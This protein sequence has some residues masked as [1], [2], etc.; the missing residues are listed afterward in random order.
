MN[1]V[2]LMIFLVIL[3]IF[4][5]AMSEVKLPSLSSCYLLLPA[6]NFE[7]LISSRMSTVI[8]WCWSGARPKPEDQHH[9]LSSCFADYLSRSPRA[10]LG[11]LD[12]SGS[13]RL[14]CGSN[15]IG[16]PS[17][18]SLEGSL[19]L[20]RVSLS[21]L[22]IPLFSKM[23]LS[24]ELRAL[25]SLRADWVA[26]LTIRRSAPAVCSIQCHSNLSFLSNTNVCMCVQSCWEIS[27][28]HLDELTR[29]YFG[30]RETT[31]V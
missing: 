30:F 24:L 29:T 16:L 7:S 2:S 15:L 28:P 20:T 8:C 19:L 12:F 26:C 31:L 4:F 11:F 13:K 22:E 14:S 9:F 10:L 1:T 21:W 6:I 27:S 23:S 17:S 5:L 18:L 25:F 3:I